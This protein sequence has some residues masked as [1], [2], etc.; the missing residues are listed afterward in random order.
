[1]IEDAVLYQAARPAGAKGIVTRDLKG[2]K[3]SELPVYNPDEMLTAIQ[4]SNTRDD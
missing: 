1:V 3:G 4:L 2:F